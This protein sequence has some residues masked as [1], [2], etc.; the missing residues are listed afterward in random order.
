[1]GKET[2]GEL[3][4]KQEQEREPKEEQYQ[5]EKPF[6]FS[7]TYFIGLFFLM[8]WVSL[9]PSVVAG[10]FYFYYFPFSLSPLNL[11]L[12]IPLFFL[13]YGIA[14]FT[15]LVA[16]K[17]GIWIVH[18]R[19]TYPELGTYRLS[20]DEPQTRA[21]IVKGN[22]KNFARWLF[23]F[24]RLNLLRA[25]WLRRMGIKVG[26]NVKLGKHVEDDDF[27]E[28]GDNN[29]MAKNTVITGH[30]INQT[31][32]TLC[33][34]IIGKNCIFELAS[35][36][37]GGIIGDNSIFTPVT[38]G[39]KGLICRGNAL[40][41]GI[42]CKKIGEYSDLSPEAIEEKKRNIKKID[43][44]DFIKEK[45]APIKINEIKLFIIKIV[46][47][48]GGCLFALL[49]IYLYILFFQTFYSPTNHLLNILILTPVPILFLIMLGAF[50][51]GA[52]I[53][54]KLFLL[55]YDHQAEVP[56]GTYELNDPLAKLFK[57]KYCLRMFGLRLIHGT[58]FKIAD[59]Y[60]MRLWGNVKLGKNVK[61]DD[62]VVDPQYLEI[63]DFAQVSACAR[64]HTHDIIDGKL[65]IK[66]VKIGKNV[67][68]GGYVHI[69]PG[70]IIA[71]G[72]FAG[73]AAWF[74]K[75]QKCSRRALWVGKPAVELPI[76]LVNRIAKAKDKYVD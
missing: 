2:Q 14:L 10:Y 29:Y 57:I 68:L 27:I 21:F 52:S 55:Y 44:K 76:E 50:I 45:N 70:V 25:F 43:K 1:M 64:I 19:I 65:F 11:L 60:V 73:I 61:M 5:E 67:L 16:V 7:Y 56:E 59:T 39:M 51:A 13:L 28:I 12:L 8:T 62:A 37:G 4:E 42:P 75:N 3:K 49:F 74:R 34:M 35:G 20:M 38:S 48:I 40:Y 24:F 31:T 47:V 9:F 69:K 72:S 23:Y 58:Y 15:S 41:H 6:T 54:I 18:K 30:Q 33:R 53:T 22:V 71:D 32:L 66:K 46:I 36:S 17:I 26:K 63:G